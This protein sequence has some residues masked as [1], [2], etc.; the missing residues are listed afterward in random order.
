MEDDPEAQLVQVLVLTSPVP[1]ALPA[2]HIEHCRSPVTALVSPALHF[3]HVVAVDPDGAVPPV[4]VVAVPA[5]QSVHD[6]APFVAP[7]AT[8]GEYF[9]K[10]QVTQVV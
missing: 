4:A 1:G 7:T 8:V 9:P 2:P 3:T 5:G 10:S 6:V